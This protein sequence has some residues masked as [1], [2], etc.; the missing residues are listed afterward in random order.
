[1]TMASRGK[2]INLFLMDGEPSGRIKCTLANWTGIA[3]KIPRIELD[4]CKGRD[5]LSQSGVYF[6]FGTSDQTDKSVV[7]I[8]QAGVR[9]NGEGILQRLRDH[10]KNEDKDY[11]TEAVVFTTSNNSFGPTEICYL[12]N[13]FTKMAFEAKRYE[14]KNSNEPSAGGRP[15]EEKESE[16]EEFIDYAKIVMGVLGH[17]VFEPLAKIPLVI[18]ADD[19]THIRDKMFYLR[20]AIKN[21]GIT[22]EASGIQTSEGF[23]VLRGSCLSPEIDDIIPNTLKQMRAKAKIDENFVLQEDVLFNSPSYAAMYVVGKFANGKTSWKTAEG[24]TLNKI[25]SEESVNL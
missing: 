7:Y 21:L 16:L 24:K 9:K 14:I 1:M 12:E 11:W 17:K 23:V 15:T 8:G 4:N 2:S 5:D 20:R 10:K 18:N 6:L 13:R 19:N 3:Y 25:E 22:V